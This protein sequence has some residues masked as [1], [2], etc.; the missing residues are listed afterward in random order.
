MRRP[1]AVV[2]A[3][4]DRELVVDRHRVVD[5][6]FLHRALHVAQVALEGELRRMHADHHQA[7]VAVTLFPLA[8]IGQGAQA[9]DAG[10]GPE[11]DQHHLAAQAFGGQ[12]RAV[13]PAGGTV[14]RR[15]RAFHRKLGTGRRIGGAHHH[16]RAGIGRL[17]GQGIQ[18]ALFQPRGADRRQPGEHAGIPA[19][20]Y[21]HH[22][23][24][25]GHAER[26]A[27]PLAR[28]QP[29]LERGEHAPANPDRQP[30]RGGRAQC[31]GQQQPAGAHA[32]TLQGSAGEDQPQDRAGA[33]R[34]QQPGGHADQQRGTHAAAP[35]I[36]GLV[37]GCTEP[38]AQPL[39]RRQ[40]AV[41]QCR[42]QQ[43]NGE[44]RHHHQR[45]PA[46]DLVGLRHP[47]AAHRGQAGHHGEHQRHADQQRQAAAQERAVGT[48]KHER[49]HRQDARAEN[50][51]HAAQVGKYKQNHR[52][53]LIGGRAGPC[54]AAS[55]ALRA[56]G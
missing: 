39:E 10:I 54:P 33:R 4:P 42:P 28:A 51:Q 35:G 22:R 48:G 45:D 13:E 31:I 50:G 5:L 52:T 26:T 7:L 41:G 47:L 55:S 34:P 19:H 24:Q 2:E 56:V 14:Q 49:Q 44:Q 6:Q 18:Q 32:G 38:R 11:I 9:V 40:Q 16:R 15:Q 36:G 8:H 20:R 3:A 30:Q 23:Q 43:C 37:G 12:R 21:G 27:D 29:P 46:P 25:R 17:A 53:F 1:V